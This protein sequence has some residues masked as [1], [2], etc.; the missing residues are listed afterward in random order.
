[1][2]DDSHAKDDNTDPS[3]DDT[4]PTPEMEDATPTTSGGTGSDEGT[5]SDDNAITDELTPLEQAQKEAY[6]MREMAQRAL[7]DLQNFKRRVEEQRGEL[8]LFANIHF[9]QA[10][11]PVI[12]NFKRAFTHIPEEITENEWVKAVSTIEKSFMDTLTS[13]GLEEIPCETGTKFDPNFHEVLMQGPGE[14]DN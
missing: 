10:I 3:T 11:F 12:D 6:E 1:M 4:T 14:K 9:L 2:H 13:L 7:A 8:I 5:S